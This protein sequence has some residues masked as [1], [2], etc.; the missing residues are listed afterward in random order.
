MKPESTRVP[1]SSIGSLSACLVEGDPEQ[2][3][4]AYKVRTRAIFVSVVLQTITVAALI[5]FPL[6][7]KGERL[8]T[9]IFVPL[10]PYRFGSEQPLKHNAVRNDSHQVARFC[11]TCFSPLTPGLQ[12]IQH[13]TAEDP[14]EDAPFIPGAPAGDPRGV[15]YGIETE[16][17]KPVPPDTIP[18]PSMDRPRR[19]VVTKIDPARLT[20]RVEP[21]YPH[22][23]LQLH[24]ETRVELHAIIAT[25]GS[26][27]SLQVLSGDPLFY[28]SAIDA[29]REWRYTP[30]L[31]NDQP[32][33]VDT[34]ITVIYSLNR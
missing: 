9:K 13:P 8:S 7:G 1:E 32:V 2:C 17:R 33:E 3:R 19:I 22:L 29:V 4:R 31:L 34:H 26:I 27:Q 12:T 25:D 18:H 21:L 15:P 10:P 24:R 11:Y 28:Q 14:G 30:T 20:R 6:L 23:A 16:P 5:V